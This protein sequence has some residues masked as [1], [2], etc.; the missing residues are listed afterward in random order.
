[1]ILSI[2]LLVMTITGALLMLKNS[3]P[4]SDSAQLQQ[5][6]PVKIKSPVGYQALL[7]EARSRFPTDRPLALIPDE[8]DV[9]IVQFRFGKDGTTKLAGARKLRFDRRTGAEYQKET[10]GRKLFE[11]ALTLHRELFIGKTYVG[12]IAVLLIFVAISGLIAYP[13]FMRGR[14]WGQIR[15]YEGALALAD[16][17]KTVAIVIAGW[18]LLMGFTGSFLAFNGALMKVYQ[19][20]ELDY[21]RK[22]Y[23]VRVSGGSQASLDLVLSNATGA[24]PGSSLYYLAFPGSEYSTEDHFLALVQKFPKAGSILG[25]E[26]RFVLV[27]ART[28]AP[29]EVLRLP[30]YL[31]WMMLSEPLHFGQFGG[32]ILK[33]AWVTFAILGSFLTL[34]GVGTSILKQKRRHYVTG[35]ACSTTLS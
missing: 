9:D 7:E 16:L 32:N 17:H 31:R 2:N 23:P 11:L 20:Q 1:M 4:D 24:F 8:K 33:W 22:K 34:T 35:R 29:A 15:G 19:H 10:Q 5:S 18:I 28:A 6:V 25:R 12:C 3:T 13:R 26:L 14:L 30:F 21:L 27:D